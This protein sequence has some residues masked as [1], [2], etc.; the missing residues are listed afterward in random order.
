MFLESFS[1][2]FES[3]I[4]IRMIKHSRLP[5]FKLFLV[6]IAAYGYDAGFLRAAAG[7]YQLKSDRAHLGPLSSF[8]NEKRD[9]EMIRAG[10]DQYQLDR[11]RGLV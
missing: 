6:N 5:I 9:D 4:V 7:A 1:S 2:G 11:A 10:W 3:D 8:F